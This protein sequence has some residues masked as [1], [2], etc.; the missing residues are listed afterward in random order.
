M[1]TIHIPIESLA[2]PK[3]WR[4]GRVYLRPAGWLKQYTD[5][6]QPKTQADKKWHDSASEWLG[7]NET[8]TA[9]FR[10][11]RRKWPSALYDEAV[12]NTRDSVALLLVYKHLRHPN[13]AV[14]IQN[15]GVAADV[16]A[17]S[18]TSVV[19]LGR[20]N[21]GQFGRHRGSVGTWTFITDDVDEY[22]ADHRMSYLDRCLTTPK[23]DRDGMQK[24]FVLALRLRS[25]AVS[26]LHDVMRVALLATALEVL[27]GSDRVQGVEPRVENLKMAQ[28]AAWLICGQPGQPYPTRSPCPLLRAT[29]GGALARAVASAH[30]QGKQVVCLRFDQVY[31]GLMADRNEAL[32]GGTIDIGRDAL[33]WHVDTLDL[34][35]LYLVE[36]VL[37]RRGA[38]MTHLDAELDSYKARPAAAHAARGGR[39]RRSKP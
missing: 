1:A 30:S 3:R 27:V 2:V 31:A 39:G 7:A 35:L 6:Y 22:F 13:A 36:W 14:D 4:V 9:E 24:R 25:L 23:D 21:V 34:V 28:R 33:W 37:A 20:R 11:R 29:S 19:T 12:E 26:V 8:V 16:S 32:H 5:S 15:F 18:I 38:S 17:G 10:T